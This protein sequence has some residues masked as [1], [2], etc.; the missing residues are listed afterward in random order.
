MVTLQNRGGGDTEETR[1]N[2]TKQR[3]RRHVV[4]LQNRG[5]GDTEETRGNFTK[6]RRRRHGGDA[7]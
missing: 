3:R 4:T 6:Q 7:W 2:F 1:G 5:G